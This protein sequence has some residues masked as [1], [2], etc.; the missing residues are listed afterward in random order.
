M[1]DAL[2]SEFFRLRR[3][4]QSWIMPVLAVGFVAT[5]YTI[6]SLLYHVGAETNRTDMQYSARIGGIFDNGIQ[7]WGFFGAILTMIVASSLIGS[8]Y[9]WNTLRPLVG[10]ASSRTHLLS[11]TLIV[12][13]L[14]TVMMVVV[15]VI[16]SIVLAAVA[17]LVID[18]SVRFPVEYLG[19]FA[20]G[21]VRW[22][23]AT[24]PY[25]VIAF[26]VAQLTRSNAAGIA[27]GIG[28]SFVE[29]LMFGLMSFM[30]DTF[31]MVQEYGIA[32]NVQRLANVSIDPESGFMEPIAASQ[33]WRS[34]G[35]LTVYIATAVV[36]SYVA[37]NRRD[38]TSG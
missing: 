3:R 7:V 15:G 38:I 1:M 19:D 28:L 25:A 37:F 34:T 6:I 26:S 36:V 27:V 30:S 33:V 11:A 9:G 17:S 10:R 13:G 31:A 32:W 23:G 14:Y 24:L 20:L 22:V 16:A 21:T 5:F 12:V 18:V 35:I 29:P 2:Q 4:P 8:E